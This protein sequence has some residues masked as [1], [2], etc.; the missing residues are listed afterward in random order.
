M[1]IGSVQFVGLLVLIAFGTAAGGVFLDS[2]PLFWCAIVV[3]A[4]AIH[5]LAIY[6]ARKSAEQGY[7][8]A[9]ARSEQSTLDHQRM[10][11]ERLREEL[12]KKLSQAEE[13]W[14][15]L[16]SMV[17]ERQR[18]S[19]GSAEFSPE[20]E[21]RTDTDPSGASNHSRKLPEPDDSGRAHSR[22]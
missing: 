6:E 14:M 17:Q 11:A 3:G 8:A 19:Q 13:Q 16:R 12:E 4:Y 1:R 15:L 21:P 20:F 2:R 10:E 18:R 22:W 7:P 9:A 5:L